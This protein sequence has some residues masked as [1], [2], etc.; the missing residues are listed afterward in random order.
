MASWTINTSWPA[1]VH[2]KTTL[3]AGRVFILTPSSAKNAD[4][5]AV[6]TCDQGA[7]VDKLTHPFDEVVTNLLNKMV[8]TT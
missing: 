1:S 5:G 7:G 6:Y 3:A 4:V 2:V 8:L